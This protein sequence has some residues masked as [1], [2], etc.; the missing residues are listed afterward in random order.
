MNR[1]L[2]GLIFFELIVV[3][4][5]DF[6]THKISNNWS[7]G[8][9]IL[10]I[11]FHL[12]FKNTFPFR[13]ELLIYPISFLC[14]GFILFNFK[15]MGGGDSKFLAG[16]FLIVPG[17]FRTIFF[18]KIILSTLVMGSILIGIQLLKRWDLT[19]AYLISRHWIGLREIVKSS[20]S[21]APVIFIAWILLGIELC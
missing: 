13:W 19:K 10:A 1:Y 4:W 15:I 6:K 2:Y 17:T 20:F 18:E 11:L 14:L 7:I 5:V 8:N 3:S 12:F 21:Y 16:L 9:L